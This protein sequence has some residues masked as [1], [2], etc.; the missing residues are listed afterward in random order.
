MAG[1][2]HSDCKNKAGKEETSLWWHGLKGLGQAW[3][4]GTGRLAWAGM[5]KPAKLLQAPVWLSLSS[6][7]HHSALLI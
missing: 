6:H 3:E 1:S 2:G 7:C 4:K 5:G